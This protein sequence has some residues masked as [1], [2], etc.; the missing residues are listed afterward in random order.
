MRYQGRN[1]QAISFPLGGI[2][3]GSIGLAGNGMLID[4]EI[5]NRPNKCSH[6]GFSFLA[7]KAE[8]DGEV[9]DARV[10]QGDLATPYQGT[11][12]LGKFSGYG[13][14]PE[15]CTL[16]GAPH[17]SQCAF[18]GSY[19]YARVELA[20]ERF[21]GK[22]AVC[23]FNPFIPSD[24]EDSG[25]P[26]AFFTVEVT[27]DTAEDLDYT[28]A[29]SLQNP[30]MDS[31]NG[32]WMQDG[33]TMLGLS[34][35]SLGE[36]EPAFGTLCLATDQED[37]QAQEY[38]YRGAWFDSLGVFWQDFCAPGPLRERTY[39]QSG[40]ED[41][42]TLAARVCVASGATECVRF[43]LAWSF[44]NF[45][46]YWNPLPKEEQT[47]TLKN[48][49][50]N[51]YAHRF[52][53]AR[54]AALYALCHWNRLDADTRAFHDALHGSTL[55]PYAIDAIS[56]TMSVLKTPT[57]I[58]LPDG[59]FYGWEGLHSTE[60]SCE[61]SCTHVWNYAYAMPFLFPRLERSLRESHFAYDLNEAGGL[62]FRT[63]IPL[64]RKYSSFRTCV[65]GQYGDILK[66]YR[67]W[68]LCGDT[69]WLKKLW[70]RVKKAVEYAWNPNNPDRW[71]PNGDGVLEGRQ[72]HTLDM[73]LFG[74]SAWLNGFYLAGLKAAAEMARAMGE[75]DAA[76]RYEQMLEN[77]RAWVEEHLFNGSYYEQQV[78]LKDRARVAEFGEDAL[79]AYWNEEAQEIKY[80]IGHGCSIDQLTGQWHAQLIGLGAILDPERTRSALR[81]I[82]EHNFLC[83]RDHFNPCR[84]YSL[85][86]ERG[87][88]MCAWPKGVEK[89]VIPVPYAQE[90]MYGFEYEA[91]VSMLLNGML[92]E[93]LEIIRSIRSRHDGDRR[94]PWNEMECGSNYA[95]SMAAYSILLALSGFSFDFTR[96]FMG[97][98][99]R[100]RQE[101]FRCFWAVDGAWGV[102][103]QDAQ[104]ARLTVP[105][106]ELR[107]RALQAGERAY[108]EAALGDAPVA[109][110]QNGWEIAFD[111]QITLQKG[112]VLALRA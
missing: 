25:I 78:D 108:Q 6:N 32:V 104:G 53:Y 24:E 77:G 107:L 12:H 80:Q 52:P 82:Y 27:N 50:K 70:P 97:F 1:T 66:T 74:P 87:V 22:A 46:Q 105:W 100:M 33:Y 18:E 4:W 47:E 106:G 48:T 30:L 20:D 40:K 93:G 42:G 31:V 43:V 60:G 99:P 109:F 29:F 96:G 94:N 49:W 95:R 110:R 15:R 36:E 67:E 76:Q 85:N 21:P 84:L 19:P 73:E 79:A 38:W 111:S 17:F 16:A 57:C 35:A 112:D 51:Y 59:T 101:D 102:Y 26:A 23:A 56:S 63:Q 89:P 83:M 86:D 81:A 11:P 103:A 92:E 2:G 55:P 61:G 41:V 14:G 91:A 72:H 65:D 34:S 28:I 68:K 71:D 98:A 75:A 44:P 88:V 62:R 9:L 45:T 58:R 7:I 54:S 13:F 90:T 8:R 37:C 64:G 69:Q 10:L 3:T 5:Q 39:A